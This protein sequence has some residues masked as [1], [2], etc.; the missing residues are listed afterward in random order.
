M[1]RLTEKNKNY[2]L[3]NSPYVLPE[4]PT[5]QGWTASEIKSKMVNPLLILYEWIRTL[6]DDTNLNEGE[7]RAIIKSIQDDVLNYKE[8]INNGKVIV[9]KAYNDATGRRIDITYETIANVKNYL[10]QMR[11]SIV[12]GTIPAHS[13]I[14]NGTIKTIQSIQDEVDRLKADS[15]NRKSILN[16][17]DY[18]VDENRISVLGEASLREFILKGGAGISID[19]SETE[20]RIYVPIAIDNKK[21]TFGAVSTD[22]NGIITNVLTIEVGG[23]YHTSRCDIDIVVANPL[24]EAEQELTKITIG[25][26][27]YSVA[28]D[29][30]SIYEKGQPNGVATLDENGKIPSVQLPSFVDDVIEK[31]S[32]DHFPE[33]GESGKIYVDTFTNK[34]YR[35]SGTQYTEISQSLALGETSSTAYAGDKGKANA[36]AIKILQNDSTNIK[37]ILNT[38]QDNLVSGVNIKTIHE[39]PLIGS[40][41]IKLKIFTRYATDNK[42]SNMSQT[43]NGESYIGHYVGIEESNNASDYK[44]IKY[45]ADIPVATSTKFGGIKAAKKHASDT[46]PVRIGDD[47]ILYVT[48]TDIS[49][50]QD[51]VIYSAEEQTLSFNIN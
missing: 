24:V 5:R 3:A 31:S 40:G 23:A 20:N 29:T 1:E 49:G 28:H 17:T 6:V 38:K 51:K 16:I 42:G 10:E 50:K 33:V 22:L 47:G 27:T 26:V 19:I 4:N 34:T 37:G 2:L 43:Y 44:W 11:L 18:I 48:P 32:I 36:E 30:I 14:S 41:D 8:D 46:R 13:Y 39:K 7:I 25:N 21:I 35:W 15:L 9:N 45:Q 12:N